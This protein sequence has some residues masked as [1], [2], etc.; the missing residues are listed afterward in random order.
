[1]V[2][3]LTN[4]VGDVCAIQVFLMVFD[5]A[6]YHGMANFM[7]SVLW[8][9]GKLDESEGVCDFHAL[10]PWALLTL[11]NPLAESAKFIGVGGVPNS[12]ELG[13]FAQLSVL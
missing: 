5:L 13:V 11:S 4:C 9:V 10:V 2:A 12:G 8:N 1:M 7:S 6:Y 3:N